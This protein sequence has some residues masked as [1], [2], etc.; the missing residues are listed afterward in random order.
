VNRANFRRRDTFTNYVEAGAVH[1]DSPRPIAERRLV[2]TPHLSSEKPVSK[3][4]FQM[5]RRTPLH[6]G[7]GEAQQN[8]EGVV[9]RGLV[10]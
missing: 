10:M 7:G 1:V 4:A 6:R 8:H 2:S 3:C 5:Q 9:G